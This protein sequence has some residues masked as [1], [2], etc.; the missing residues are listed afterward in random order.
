MQVADEFR[1]REQVA[2]AFLKATSPAKAAPVLDIP[3]STSIM[4]HLVV[5]STAPNS[6]SHPQSAVISELS[7]VTSSVSPEPIADSTS[8]T[9][10]KAR[11]AALQVS[12]F[13]FVDRNALLIRHRL[14]VPPH[15][16]NQHCPFLNRA[17]QLRQVKKDPRRCYTVARQSK[18]PPT[19]LSVHRLIRKH[20]SRLP[21]SI[22][23]FCNLQTPPPT[24][25]PFKTRA[26]LICTQPLQREKT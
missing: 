3:Q 6:L 10:L 19:T 13:F 20:P 26:R 1:A 12:H 2:S 4:A 16:P 21:T 17:L 23:H 24:L 9:A 11:L 7:P 8:I 14:P 25:H 18:G 15:L 5:K 22:P